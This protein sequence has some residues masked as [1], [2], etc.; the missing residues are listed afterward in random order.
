MTTTR[1]FLR[2]LLL[3]LLC[4]GL[5]AV[6]Q[7][8]NAASNSSKKGKQPP[9]ASKTM[10]KPSAPVAVGVN[11]NPFP[12]IAES[13][14]SPSLRM[15]VW[16]ADNPALVSHYRGGTERRVIARCALG[17]LTLAPMTVR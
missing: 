3:M 12:S 8:A 1:F 17:A 15:F 2:P 11:F 10:L 16:P 5:L 7:L 13:L 6:T 14:T 4:T 9:A